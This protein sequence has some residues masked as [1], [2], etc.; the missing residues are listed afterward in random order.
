MTQPSSGVIPEG[1]WVLDRERSN[2]F[3]AET[4]TLWFVKDD[5]KNLIWVSIETDRDG[6]T[7]VTSWSGEYGGPP[8][9]VQGNDF[10]GTLTSPAPGVMRN[11][12]ELKG[13]GTYVETCTLIENN[14]RLRCEGSTDDGKTTWVEEFV[15]A[16]PNLHTFPDLP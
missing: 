1:M 11:T 4:H 5:G 13:S 16:G 8:V 7:H 15:W 6:Q 12:G 9:P 3:M 2:P 14:T 10:I